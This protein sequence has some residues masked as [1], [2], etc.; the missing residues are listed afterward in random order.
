[1]YTCSHLELEYACDC[2]SCDCLVD[3][4]PELAPSPPLVPPPPPPS[5]APTPPPSPAPPSLSVGEVCP[6]TCYASTCDWWGNHGYTCDTLENIYSCTCVGCAC[7]ASPPPPLPSV[8]R[9]T[10]ASAPSP[11]TCEDK[12][13]SKKCKKALNKGKCDKKQIMKKCALTCSVC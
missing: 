12:K 1:M 13:S 6:A 3:A 9:T 7:G 2:S 11:P 8:P 10:E 4:M 5:P